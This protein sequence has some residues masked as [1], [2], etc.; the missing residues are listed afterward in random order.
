MPDPLTTELLKRSW[1]NP[2]NRPPRDPTEW[3]SNSAWPHGGP[4]SQRMSIEEQLGYPQPDWNIDPDNQGLMP[5]GQ[6]GLSLA[7]DPKATLYD[8]R[9]HP[10][11]Y[12]SLEELLQEAPDEDA[13]DNADES[14]EEKIAR[15][16]MRK[17]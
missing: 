6:G 1:A 3:K 16:M 15:L 17:F 12:P 9:A 5:N 10:E 2:A 4:L 14:P 11:L 8:I 7:N 13:Q